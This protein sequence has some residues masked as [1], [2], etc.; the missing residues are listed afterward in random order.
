MSALFKYFP[1][2]DYRTAWPPGHVVHMSLDRRYDGLTISIA[3]CDCGWAV[4]VRWRDD[5]ARLLQDAAIENHWREVEA[6]RTRR[7]NG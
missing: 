5:I 3:E 2:T 4:W 1:F 6:Q 7:A